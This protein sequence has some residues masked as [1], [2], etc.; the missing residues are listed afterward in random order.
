MGGARG[1][2]L[3]LPIPSEPPAKPYTASGSLLSQPQGPHSFLL[4]SYVLN[5]AAEHIS[6]CSPAQ[7]ALLDRDKGSP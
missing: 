1:N 3:C 2:F 7:A 5:A 6:L 4:E